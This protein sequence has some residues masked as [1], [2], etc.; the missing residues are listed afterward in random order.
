MSKLAEA[1]IHS[2]HFFKSVKNEEINQL[3]AQLEASLE[4]NNLILIDEGLDALNQLLLVR[5]P[6]V[7]AEISWLLCSISLHGDAEIV[8]KI[9]WANILKLLRSCHI[10]GA[11]LLGILSLCDN[12]K[13]TIIVEGSKILIDLSK[14][15]NIYDEDLSSALSGALYKFSLNHQA[16]VPLAKGGIGNLIRKWLRSDYVENITDNA[17]K[18]LV[19]MSFS[20][21]TKVL[22]RLV[23]ALPLVINFYENAE[24]DLK[25]DIAFSV[26]N[27]LHH[28]K[29][30]DEYKNFI[31]EWAKQDGKYKLAAAIAF[32]NLAHSGEK[33]EDDVLEIVQELTTNEDEHIASEAAEAIEQSNANPEAPSVPDT[34]PPGVPGAAPVVPNTPPPSVPDGPPGVPEGPPP[35]V[36]D[37]PPPGVPDGPPPGVPDGPPPGVPD[38]PPPDTLGGPPM[39]E[40]P[41]VPTFVTDDEKEKR[42]MSRRKKSKAA[43]KAMSSAIDTMLAPVLNCED[44]EIA[45]TTISALEEFPEID[46]FLQ[47]DR[48]DNLFDVIE[49]YRTYYFF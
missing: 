44:I 33:F 8:Q 30:K 40:P 42:R 17:I 4:E 23:T 20:R 1:G 19:N 46:S 14:D 24:A 2:I 35:G 18:L 45:L 27:L 36:P 39:D 34:L 10:E 28:H 48:L 15:S 32:N 31:S 16:L 47:H 43:I 21:T 7:L 5:N 25:L 26:A 22:S 38:G 9:G 6:L 41:S 11:K 37:G 13:K 29:N 49:T 3:G 12:D